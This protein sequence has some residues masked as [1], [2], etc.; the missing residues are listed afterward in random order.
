MIDYK[1]LDSSV[2]EDD[3]FDDVESEVSVPALEHGFARYGDFE[4]VGQGKVTNG[5]C[6]KFRA[7]YACSRED[8]HRLIM[9]DGVNFAGKVY[10]KPNFF[11]CDKPSCPICYKFGWA[12][13]EARR[14]ELRLK[15][16][17]K[18]FGLVEHVVCSV[19]PRDYGLS[20]EGLRLKAIQ[21]LAVRGVVGGVLIFHG[22]RYNERRL[23]YW[24]P[25]FHCLGFLLGGYKCRGCKRKSN[26]L[27]GCGGFDDRSYQTFLKD[28]WYVKVLGKR[29]SV[30]HTAW[31][32]LNHASVK[33][34]V[35]R[36]HVATWFGVCS[37]RKLKVTVEYKKAVCPICQHDL[38]E[39]SYHGN[40]PD[41]LALSSSDRGSCVL[42]RGFADLVEGG[43]VVWV[44][45]VRHG[46][47]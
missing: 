6:G 5:N 22:F 21:A 10:F 37:Y 12:V 43:R 35:K 33:V 18:R 15:E 41:I 4:L 11:S 19:A 31:Y 16:A 40:K 23:W 25:H 30:Y 24:S 38:V 46:F 8:L 47:G 27:K 34:G 3:V 28:G 13:R 44:E 29:K 42:R 45:V 32:Q 17:D 36:F 14:I 39:H 26:C 7:L 20:F 9:L 2:L 1:N